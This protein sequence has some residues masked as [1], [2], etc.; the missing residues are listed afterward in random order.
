MKDSEIIKKYVEFESFTWK[1]EICPIKNSPNGLFH[2][3]KSEKIFQIKSFYSIIANFFR[4]ICSELW[5]LTK[6]TFILNIFSLFPYE[7][8]SIWAV[9]FNGTYFSFLVNDPNSAYFFYNFRILTLAV[10]NLNNFFS[11]HST[12]NPHNHSKTNGIKHS[13]TNN[14]FK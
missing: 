6:D 8:I 10:F 11:A 14:S 4:L 7:N 1:V 3:G 13:N 12:A 5:S 2:W 9:V